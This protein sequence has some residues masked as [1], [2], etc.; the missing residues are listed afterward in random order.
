MAEEQSH[1]NRV[2]FRPPA[3]PNGGQA[4]WKCCKCL[5]GL[6]K[7]G[8]IFLIFWLIFRPRNVKFYVTEASLTQFNFTAGKNTTLHYNLALNMSVRNSNK[9]FG[10]HY[11]TIEATAY[12]EDQRF[13]TDTLPPFYQGHKNTSFLNPV[14]VGQQLVLLGTDQLSQFN[15]EKLAGVYTIDV[16]LYLRI[17]LKFGKKAFGQFKVVKFGKVNF[18]GFRPKVKCGLKV[19]LRSTGNSS[20]VFERTKCH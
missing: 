7:I 9:K 19:P 17:R 10:I 11:D 1:Q 16:K 2:Y 15:A 20:V 13:G 3:A 8:L 6:L 14:F 5:C 18:S 4:C 12:Y